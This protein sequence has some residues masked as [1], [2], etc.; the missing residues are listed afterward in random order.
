[1]F[2]AAVCKAQAGTPKGNG[3][4]NAKDLRMTGTQAAW[5]ACA[6]RL[7]EK[8]AA[9]IAAS[10]HLRFNDNKVF[11]GATCAT[12]PSTV[13]QCI[14]QSTGRTVSLTIR[15]GD[16]TGDPAFDVPVTISCD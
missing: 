12:C 5:T 14:A 11:Q 13:A 4:V 9:P 6:Q 3:A 2:N 15:G 16:V 8:P 7:K 10:V 1:V